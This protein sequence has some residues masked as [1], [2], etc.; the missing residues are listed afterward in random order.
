MIDDAVH[1]S[2]N[3]KTPLLVT[4]LYLLYTISLNRKFRKSAPA[5]RP[6]FSWLTAAMVAH[7]LVMSAFSFVVFKNTFSILVRFWRTFG[8]REFV[9][10]SNKALLA[11]LRFY[12]WVFYASK[13]V[14]ILDTIIVHLNSRRTTFLQ[15]YHH[16]GAIVCC[17]M[18]CCAQ[19]HVAWIFVTF[20]SF[21]HTVMYLYYSLVTLRIRTKFKKT[22]T[23][24]QITQF[25]VGALL[26]CA[27]ACT[28]TVFSKD[29]ALRAFQHVTAFSN[30][31]YVAVL[32]FLFKAF[33]RRAYAKNAKAE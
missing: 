27:Y 15:M 22:V 8:F 18:L 1:V 6:L 29:P 14:E 25:V 30:L 26:F 16:A 11:Q 31:A 32:F 7:N 24:L 2:L 17:W 21:V 5:Q 28:G 33:A 3:F 23:Q 13:Y 4:L 12:F 9:H 10:D 20:N 19:S